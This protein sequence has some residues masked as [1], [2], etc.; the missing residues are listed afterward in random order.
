MKSQ[1]SPALTASDGHLT[2]VLVAPPPLRLPSTIPSESR[3]ATPTTPKPNPRNRPGEQSPVPLEA[4]Y[5]LLEAVKLEE[6]L[7]KTTSARSTNVAQKLTTLAPKI[8]EQTR[9]T[10]FKQFLKL[11]EARGLVSVQRGLNG[12]QDLITRVE[13]SV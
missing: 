8:Y 6:E 10:S 9:T 4:F 12:S 3:V 1:A 11:A 5:P 7:R 2:G 13:R